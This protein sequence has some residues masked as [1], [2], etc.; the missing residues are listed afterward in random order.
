M[1]EDE[2]MRGA[3]VVEPAKLNEVIDKEQAAFDAKFVKP[4]SEEPET[5][6]EME[7]GK[8]P[9]MKFPRFKV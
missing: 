3:M 9:P 7:A 4:T 2:H 6:I 5:I 8:P 1:G